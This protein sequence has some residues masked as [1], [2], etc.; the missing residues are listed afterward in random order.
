M[1]ILLQNEVNHIKQ[2]VIPNKLDLYQPGLLKFS[3]FMGSNNQSNRNNQRLSN[4][5]LKQ[6]IPNLQTIK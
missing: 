3:W 4:S 1:M 2:L 5:I 6:S